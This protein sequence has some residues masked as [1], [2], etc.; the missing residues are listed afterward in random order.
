MNV[1]WDDEAAVAVMAATPNATADAEKFSRR[2]LLYADAKRELNL[3]GTSAALFAAPAKDLLCC[4]GKMEADL[5]LPLGVESRM[6]G[7]VNRSI[8]WTAGCTP[9]TVDGHI[10]WAK[11]GG[12]RYM[13]IYYTA[14]FKE[15][16]ATPSTA[17]TT[18]GTSTRTG[19]PT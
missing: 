10:K 7:K 9:E 17:T 1:V 14:I 13:M 19:R 4:V 8:F 11:L 16:G 18:G 5:G 2:R 3:I 15:R 12:F 6:S